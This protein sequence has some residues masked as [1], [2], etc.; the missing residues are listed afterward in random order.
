MSLVRAL[1]LCVIIS[2][3]HE[4]RVV[5]HNRENALLTGAVKAFA[6][7]EQ[8]FT[9]SASLNWVSLGNAVEAMPYE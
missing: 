8:L 7:E 1:S 5:L 4:L 3:W 2:L 6:N 9:D